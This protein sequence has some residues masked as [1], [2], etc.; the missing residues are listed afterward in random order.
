[1][2]AL[3]FVLPLAWLLSVE[4]PATSHSPLAPESPEYEPRPVRVPGATYA[5]VGGTSTSL[6]RLRLVTHNVARLASHSEIRLLVTKY[7]TNPSLDSAELSFTGTDCIYTIVRGARFPNNDVLTFMRGRGCAPLLGKPT[8]EVRLTFRFSTPGLIAVWTYLPPLKQ[9]PTRDDLIVEDRAAPES[10]ARPIVR[11]TLVDTYPSNR[12]RRIDL[13]AYVWQVSPSSR[14]LWSAI[15]YGGLLIWCAAFCFAGEQPQGG[16]TGWARIGRPAAGA[17]CAAAALSVTHAVVVPPFQAADEPNHFLG[18]L[19]LAG[20]LDLGNDATAWAR[21]GHFERIQFHPD[22][23]FGPFDVGQPGAIWNDGVAPDA[24]RGSGAAWIWRPIGSS[25]AS[26]GVPRMLLTIRLV[27]AVLFSLAVAA[28]VALLTLA[29]GARHPLLIAVPLF[30]IPT[31]PF[32]GMHLSNYALLVDLYMLL[33]T[34]VLI[35]FWDGDNSHLAGPI[36]GAAWVAGIAVSRSAIPL[37]AMIAM[38]LVAR[39]VLGGRGQSV[40]SALIFWMGFSAWLMVGVALTDSEY[41]RSAT[42]AV[43]TTLPRAAVFAVTSVVDHPWILLAFGAFAAGAEHGLGLLRQQGAAFEPGMRSAAR[44]VAVMASVVVFAMLA[45]SFI[46]PYPLLHSIDPARPPAVSQYVKDAALAGLT[47]FR[48]GHPDLLTSVTFW[49]GFGWL[50][51]LPSDLLVSALAGASGVALAGWFVWIAR[52]GSYRTLV[53]LLCVLCAYALTLITYAISVVRVT[54]ADLHGRYLLG[55]YLCVL[56]VAWSSPARFVEQVSQP[57]LAA[58]VACVGT[59]CL[60]LHVYSLA[61]IITRYF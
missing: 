10:Y 56:L 29:C 32:F 47:A 41:V 4:I 12:A 40:R 25:L 43:Q 8:G 15:G 42:T 34:G 39:L 23:R 11:G 3:A 44:I 52:T 26:A 20:R 59:C 61:V 58:L 28:S 57:R 37:A 36:V 18:V 48:F 17:F 35:A 9:P 24:G 49:G 54:P 45:G 60:G 19:S 13:L 50:D 5:G 7:D 27:H 6:Y 33:A 1:M 14:W 21:L 55:L 51:T 30:L 31:L 2:F 38:V 22:E 46:F 53:W 16:S